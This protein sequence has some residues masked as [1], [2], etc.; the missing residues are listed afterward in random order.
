MF[1]WC[2]YP[3]SLIKASRFHPAWRPWPLPL[4][5]VAPDSSCCPGLPCP[6]CSPTGSALPGRHGECWP[7]GLWSLNFTELFFVFS[8]QNIIR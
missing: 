2:P 6:V 5:P 8:S 3:L 7:A 1:P 4:V